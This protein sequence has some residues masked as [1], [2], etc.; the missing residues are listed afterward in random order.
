M[1]MTVI[2]VIVILSFDAHVV[3]YDND[4]D[5]DDDN[6]VITVVMMTV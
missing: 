6:F 2:T 3:E 5:D 1:N 4:D